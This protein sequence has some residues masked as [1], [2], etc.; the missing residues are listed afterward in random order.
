MYCVNGEERTK[1]EKTRC[2][3][4]FTVLKQR[5]PGLLHCSDGFPR[6]NNDLERT[7]RALNRHDRR[8]SGR[9]NWNASVLRDGRCVAS[10]EWWLHQPDREAQIQARFRARGSRY[11]TATPG[12]P[13]SLSVSSSAIG[14]PG[15]IGK[16]AGA[17]C[18]YGNLA[19]IGEKALRPGT[20]AD[21]LPR[22]HRLGRWGNNPTTIGPGDRDARTSRGTKQTE[23]ASNAHCVLPWSQPARE[24]ERRSGI[25]A[26]ASPAIAPCKA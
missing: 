3:E 5:R 24:P 6:T 2:G 10:Q 18:R 9:N 4:R 15:F 13:P 8:I 1:E 20:G 22:L 12:A 19:S 23:C 11:A 21:H 17:S 26:P 16:T 25:S 7:P 14:V